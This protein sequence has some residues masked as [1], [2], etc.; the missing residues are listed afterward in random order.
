[1]ANKLYHTNI[2]RLTPENANR[3]FLLN[4]LWICGNSPY[5][6][7]VRCPLYNGVRAKCSEYLTD[8]IMR[9]PIHGFIESLRHG[10][11]HLH[12]I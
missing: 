1:M 9:A 2:S 12:F 3:Q 11:P 5:K 10:A 6:L 4:G 7:C 8:S